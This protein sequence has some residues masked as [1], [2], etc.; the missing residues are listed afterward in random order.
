MAGVLGGEPWRRAKDKLI[1]MI[2]D[3]RDYIMNSGDD[4]AL[5][6]IIGQTGSGKTHLLKNIRQTLDMKRFEP[7]YIDLTTYTSDHLTPLLGKIVAEWRNEIMEGLKRRITKELKKLAEN[8][9]KI[10]EKALLGGTMS[11]VSVMIKQKKLREITSNIING[12]RK[13]NYTPLDKLERFSPLIIEALRTNESQKLVRGFK[14]EKLDINDFN[15]LTGTLNEIGKIGVLLFDEL[16]GIANKKRRSLLNE[17][18]GLINQRP[19]LVLLFAITPG[20]LTD[21]EEIDPPFTRRV[22]KPRVRCD[23]SVPKSYKEVFHVVK[24]Y[25]E[26]F[27]AVLSKDERHKLKVLINELFHQGIR[28]LGDILPVISNALSESKGQEK[29]THASIEKALMNT[30]LGVTSPKSEV[31]APIKE[32]LRISTKLSNSPKE[33]AENLT[34]SIREITFQAGKLGEIEYLH[35]TSKEIPLD[36]N[37]EI[38]ANTDIYLEKNEEKGCINIHISNDG[39]ITPEMAEEIIKIAENGRI[40][41]EPIDFAILLS[42]RDCSTTIEKHP[43]I[44]VCTL[45]KSEIVDLIYFAND[46]VEE[47]PKEL[48]AEIN[49][50]LKQLGV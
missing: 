23:I 29:I 9:D 39:H 40:E 22:A 13:L 34:A 46:R 25:F 12:K 14:E 15:F 41:D 50:F 26:E 33:L 7:F 43:N 10:A 18:K 20:G 8:G 11:K 16:G 21:L 19:P 6:T 28:T 38:T 42:N 1:D 37:G 36:K 4:F 2:H 3:T 45:S 35:P 31:G 30:R 27:N 48:Q 5:G 47:G 44:H 17:L 49:N 24:T 32:Y